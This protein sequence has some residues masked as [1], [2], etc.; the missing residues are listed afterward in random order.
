MSDLHFLEQNPDRINRIWIQIFHRDR[1]RIWSFQNDQI[2]F[3][4]IIG[5]GPTNIFFLPIKIY[6]SRSTFVLIYMMVLILDGSLD[7]SVHV[8]R[9]ISVIWFVSGICLDR[10]N[11]QIGW[12][13]P[14][15]VFFLTGFAIDDDIRCP[16]PR[17]GNL[18]SI[19]SHCLGKKRK[20]SKMFFFL[21]I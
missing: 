4:K 15:R 13:C 3:F 19:P 20:L 8:R 6:C 2:I 9:A 11:S 21:P 18:P 5:K 1:I 17:A 12:C 16:L 10:E 7:I 14:K